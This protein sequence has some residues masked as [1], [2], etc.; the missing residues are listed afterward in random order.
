MSITGRIHRECQNWMHEYHRMRRD[1]GKMVAVYVVDLMAELLLKLF[2]DPDSACV[3]ASI[4]SVPTVL[5]ASLFRYPLML[6]LKFLSHAADVAWHNTH[7]VGCHSG[8][9]YLL[10]WTAGNTR[11][12]RLTYKVLW[13]ITHTEID[14]CLTSFFCLKMSIT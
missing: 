12:L 9:E 6:Q 1:D 8:M 5:F 13:R 14:T 7:E 4:H 11:L 3:L 10:T 2:T